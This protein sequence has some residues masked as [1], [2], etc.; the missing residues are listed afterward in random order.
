MDIPVTKEVRIPTIEI[1]NEIIKTKK[2]LYL[3]IFES[4]FI[5]EG[6]ILTINPGGLEGSE[7]MA[8]DGVVLFG[9]KNVF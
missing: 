2:R 4:K 8:K 6:T 7:R 3:R 9:T 5:A 1:P